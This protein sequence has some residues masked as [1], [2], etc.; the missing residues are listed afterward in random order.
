MRRLLALVCAIVFVDTAFYAVVA[1]LLPRYA[2]ELDLSKASAGV[3]LGIYAAGTLLAAIPTGLL[4]MRWG[5]RRTVLVGLA[6]LAGSSLVFG[7]AQNVVLL[8]AARFAQGVAG[9]CTW[10]GGLAWLLTAAPPDRRGEL[11]G[12]ALSAAIA[13]ALFGPVIGAIA[14]EVG[15]E[16]VF[17]SVVV[18]AGVLAALALRAGGGEPELGAAGGVRHAVRAPGVAGAMWL[19]ALPAL[20][21]GV[22]DV[23]VPLRMDD[24]GAS[25]SAIALAFLVAAGLEAATSP[26]S[27]RFSDRRGR[28]MPIRAGLL[29][30]AV[31]TLLVPVPGSPLGVGAMLVVV[32]AVL[33]LF[34]AP[35]MALLSDAAESAGS[36]Q[37]LAFALCN[38]AWAAGITVGAA[39]GGA[40]A[41]ATA[42]AVPYALFAA[43]CLVTLAAIAGRARAVL[44]AP[45]GTRGTGSP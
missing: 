41:K 4:A 35:A 1:P 19:V 15:T 21:F 37:G 25:A 11:I 22:L 16:P 17:G 10:A 5:G 40:L 23:L 18:V 12:T 39:G 30:A 44:P 20:G 14:A 9:A 29:G 43:A 3:L 45:A 42:D 2:E 32:A 24:L 13:G 8:D 27:G 33:G 34:W 36:G 26:V 28:L 38:F 7:L 6:G 31:L